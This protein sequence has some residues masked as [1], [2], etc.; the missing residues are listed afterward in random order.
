MNLLNI[1]IIALIVIAVISII[2]YF[3]QEKLI[4]KPEKLPSDFV[5]QYGNQEV[6]E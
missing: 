5:F 4:F 3:V 6:K 1:V 2:F